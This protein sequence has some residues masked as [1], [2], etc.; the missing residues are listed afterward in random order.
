M[1]GK[2]HESRAYLSEQPE[3]STWSRIKLVIGL[4]ALGAL[5]LFLLQNFQ[6]AEVNFLWF[7]WR[8]RVVWAL[9]GAAIA[10]AIATILW[11]TLQAR[12]RRAR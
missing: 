6:G 4:V 2:A 12:G 1:Q 5:I 10:G 7:T 9:L 3:G 8:T 11:G